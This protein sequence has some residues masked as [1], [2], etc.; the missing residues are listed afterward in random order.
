MEKTKLS[1]TPLTQ[2][3]TLIYLFVSILWIVFSDYLLA[4]WLQ[5]PTLQQYQ[6]AQT[7]KGW[8]FVL[9]TACLLYLLIRHEV[10]QFQ[11]AQAILH[12]NEVQYQQE[13]HQQMERLE[14]ITETVAEGLL[15]LDSQQQIIHLNSKAQEYLQDLTEARLGDP[16]TKLGPHLFAEKV[17]DNDSDGWVQEITLNG[18]KPRLFDV[19]AWPKFDADQLQGWALIIRDVTAKRQQQQYIQQQERLAA[20]GQLASGIAHDFNNVMAII[21][22]YSQL[23]HH[24]T[25]LS[26]KGKRQLTNIYQQALHAS[27]LIEQILDFSRSSIVDKTHIDLVPML[28][29]MLKLWQRILPATITI[30]LEHDA[31]SY[32]IYADPTRIQQ[33]LMNLLVNGRDA[34]NGN[35]HL[36]LYLAAISVAPN[37][38]G[39]LPTMSAGEWVK[40]MLSDNGHGIA[41]HTLDRIFEPFFTTKKAGEGTGLGLAQVY[42]I[43]EQH[44][45]VI[46]V[47]SE[48]DKGTTF[49]IYLPLQETAVSKTQPDTSEPTPASRHETTILL[50][51]DNPFARQAIADSLINAGYLVLTAENG[52]QALDIFSQNDSPIDIVISDL[53]M[54]V[55]GGIE[56]YQR[57]K[58]ENKQVSTLLITGYPLNHQQAIL[59]QQQVDWL[60]KPFTTDELVNKLNQVLVK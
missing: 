58:E 8:S 45:G 17:S 38:S 24:E 46:D 57:L 10:R 9:V 12:A 16:L 42:G 29:E 22:L 18:E 51:E 15:L 27:K 47:A 25:G 48:V 40:I 28:K 56:L 37:K 53:V 7:Y 41:A 50:V 34:V 30:S 33:M 1:V 44:G 14:W 31:A 39:P 21:V 23:L 32:N 60:Q 4:S 54:P 43:V 26:S 3:I 49:T 35:G 13:L 2:R 59:E 20:I 6:L 52:Q 11:K 55:M 5:N 36:S 19:R